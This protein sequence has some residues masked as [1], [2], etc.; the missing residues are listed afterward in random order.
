MEFKNDREFAS[1]LDTSDPLAGMRKEYLFP[2]HEGKP[3]LYFTGNS[4][5][6]QP[7]GVKESLLTECEDWEK[8]AVEGHFKARHPWY[9]YHEQFAVGSAALV[10]ALT[11][12]VVVM[13]QLTVNLHLLLVSFYRPEGKRRKILFETKPFPSDQYAF[14]TQARLHG[15]EP[16]DVLVEMQPRPGERTLR[17]GDIVSEIRRLGDELALVC[18]G[19]VNYFTGQF[20]DLQA[21]T[22]AAHAA[23]AKAG[24]DLAHTAGNLPLQLHDWKVDFACWCTYKY[25]NSGPGSVGGVYIHENHVKNTGLPRLGGWWGHKK[26]TRFRME[27]GYDP[28]LSAEAWQLSNAPVFSMAVHRVALD[29]FSKVGMK[30]LRE[31]SLK[32]TAYLEFVLNEVAARTGV[33]LEIITPSDPA[34]RGCQ[35]SVVVPGGSRSIVET[36]SGSGAIVDWREPNVIRMAPVPMYNSFTDIFTFG[37]IFQHVLAK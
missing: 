10:G 22:T 19:G 20:F 34:Q 17:T 4:L 2:Q 6:L 28:M 37:E 29:L 9:S 21:I 11:H 27:P 36:L 14:E 5:G 12:E 31:K 32:L 1:G 16:E 8:F 15:L 26:E 30:A 13:N 24:F 18:F 33:K 23:G 35:L 3:V 7:A 25:L